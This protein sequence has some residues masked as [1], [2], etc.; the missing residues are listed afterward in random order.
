[1]PLHPALQGSAGLLLD[2]DGTLY[3][4]RRPILGAVEI[5][6]RLRRMRLK[7]RFVTNTT[8]KGRA[9][10]VEHLHALGFEAKPEEIFNP[11]VAAAALLRHEGA[12]AALFVPDAALPDFKGVARDDEH[13]DVVVVGDLGDGWTF[14]T[15]NRA[16]R[17]VH[18]KGARL[19]GLGRTR[20]WQAADGLRLDVGPFVAALEAA[21]GQH[22]VVVGKPDPAFF[23][24]AAADLKV[25]PGRLAVVGDDVETDVR[26]AQRAGLRGVLVRTGKFREKDLAGGL[27][28]TLVLDS[29]ADLVA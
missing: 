2:L 6:R 27:A 11:G 8:S 14:E 3:E 22:A 25:E 12:K 4:D 21:T 15:L 28:P 19:M 1:M 13:P 18:E 7:V 29:V 5:V 16:F 26:A 24:A 17:L 9:A 10:I 23:L 20:Y